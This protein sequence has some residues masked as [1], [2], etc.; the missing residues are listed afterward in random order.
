[1]GE[2][3]G[4]PLSPAEM[5]LEKIF[6]ARHFLKDPFFSLVEEGRGVVLA[7]IQNLCFKYSPALL[8]PGY[9]AV[10]SLLR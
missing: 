5:S 4:A 8:Y 1:M 6:H 7:S 3:L 10:I 2:L 9:S